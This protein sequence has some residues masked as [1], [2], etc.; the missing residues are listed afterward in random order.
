MSPIRAVAVLL[1]IFLRGILKV[2]QHT[3]WDQTKTELR[4]RFGQQHAMLLLR[5]LKQKSSEIIQ[6]YAERL[7]AIAEDAFDGPDQLQRHLIGYFIDGL[8]QDYIMMKVVRDN[9]PTFNE[10]VRIAMGEQNLG[11]QFE[12]RLGAQNLQANKR[13]EMPMEIGHSRSK[14]MCHFCK[15]RGHI[16]KDSRQRIKC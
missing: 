6:V 16:M 8:I 12:L 1:V 15:K 9:P 2:S 4:S 14:I 3:N 13:E 10:A 7:L 5:C 11:K